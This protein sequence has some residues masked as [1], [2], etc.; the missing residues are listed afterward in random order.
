MFWTYLK[1][2]GFI[3]VL[4]DGYIDGLELNR[5]RVYWISSEE[6]ITMSSKTWNLG[7]LITL[8]REKKNV[9][10]TMQIKLKVYIKAGLC[11]Y[12]WGCSEYGLSQAEI[13]VF[14][15]DIHHGLKYK[16]ALKILFPPL[17]F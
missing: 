1:K 7:Q 16:Y 4:K 11:G 9:L 2:A 15:C 10:Q 3:I 8:H 12:R 17:K 14:S 5:A 6:G 13:P